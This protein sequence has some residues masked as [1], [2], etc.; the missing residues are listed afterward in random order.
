MRPGGRCR[1]GVAEIFLDPKQS[2]TY[3]ALYRLLVAYLLQHEGWSVD[4][5]LNSRMKLADAERMLAMGLP[6]D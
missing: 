1:D 3:Y 6:A 2:G 4:R 5:L